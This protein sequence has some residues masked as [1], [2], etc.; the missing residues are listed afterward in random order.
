MLANKPV[1]ILAV[2]LSPSP[3]LIDSDLSACLVRGLP[4]LMAGDLNAKHVEWSSRLITRRG[5]LLGDD[6]DKNSC[7]NYG[8]STPT[9]LPYNP[10]ATPDVIDIAITKDPVL[11]LRL[12]TC[13]ALSSD[14]LPELID[15]QC[16]SSFLIPPDRPHLRKTDWPKFQNCLEAGLPSNPQP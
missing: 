10:S 7:L 4:V 8:P 1:K 11:P 16:R 14:H 9:T 13:S 2:Y 12:T 3:P 5:R 15:T 6:A